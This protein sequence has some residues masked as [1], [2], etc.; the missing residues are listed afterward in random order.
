MAAFS[1]VIGSKRIGGVFLAI[2]AIAGALVLA[3]FSVR[4][5]NRWI[6]ADPSRLPPRLQIRR[7]AGQLQPPRV[8]DPDVGALYAPNDSRVIETDDFTYT[9]VTDQRG[10]P[11]ASFP[12]R[13]D[14]VFLGDS[15]LIAYGVG[16]ANGVV[17]LVDDALGDRS[18]VNLANGGAGPARQWR[19]YERYGATMGARLVISCIFLASD[20]ENDL[21]FRSWR[22]DSMGMTYDQFRWSYGQRTAPPTPTLA[23]RLRNRYAAVDWLLAVVEPQLWGRLR[24]PHTVSLS[25]GTLRLDVDKVTFARSEYSSDHPDVVLLA[26]EVDRLR[27]LAT[28]N[29]ATLAVVLI[30]SKEEVYGVS[31]AANATGAAAAVASRLRAMGMPVLDLMTTLRTRGR[32]R[33]TYY[34]RDIHLNAFGS[35]VAAGA[36]ADWIRTLPPDTGHTTRPE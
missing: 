31:R 20:F 19:I 12:G 11:N 5:A 8:P 34:P 6:M 27:A 22:D 13:A 7:Q 24:V 9:F 33:L 36:I 14:I 30:P 21:H 23:G 18:A 25:D 32:E 15:L 28:G 35:Q 17:P 4:A 3:Q 1:R 26:A 10:F 16:I 2:A 29:G